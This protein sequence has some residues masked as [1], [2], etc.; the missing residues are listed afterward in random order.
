MLGQRSGNC[1]RFVV[2]FAVVQRL[3]FAGFYCIPLLLGVDVRA[4]TAVL[5]FGC[6]NGFAA[7]MTPSAT[8]WLMDLTP[9]DLRQEYFSRREIALV[10]TAAVPERSQGFKN[11]TAFPA[12]TGQMHKSVIESPGRPLL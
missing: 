11:A 12:G 8:N 6:A 3:L 5:I 9:G 7:F 1:K 2:T 10:A 4:A